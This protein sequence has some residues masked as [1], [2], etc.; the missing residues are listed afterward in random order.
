VGAPLLLT[1]VDVGIACLLLLFLRG[2]GLPVGGDPLFMPAFVARTGPA[3][4]WGGLFALVALQGLLHVAAFHSKYLLTEGAQLRLRLVLGRRL[5]PRT[6]APP[7]LSRLGHLTGEVLP[8][9]SSVLFFGIQLLAFVAQA[10]TL[11]LA[12]IWVAPRE[13]AVGLLGL[14]AAGTAVL[15]F[16]RRANRAAAGVPASHLA[17]EESKVRAARSWLLIR[18]LRLEEPERRRYVAACREMHRACVE[19]FFFANLG[20]AV[21]PLVALLVLAAT[22]LARERLFHTPAAAFVAFLYLFVRFQYLVAHGSH[23]VG[24][25]FTSTPY[26]RE[27]A[28]LLAEVPADDRTAALAGTAPARRSPAA[29]AAEPPPPP[30]LEAHDLSFRW[31]GQERPVL[32]GLT[33]DAAPGEQLGIVGPNGCGKSTFLALV[34]GALEPDRG[35]VKLDG[36]DAAEWLARHAAF[37]GYVGPE[38]CLVAGTIRQNLCYGLERAT[39]DGELL[40]ALERAGFGDLSRRLPGGLDQMVREDGGGLS[41]GEKQKLALARA[42]LRRPALL[43]LDEPTANVDERSEAEMVDTLLALRERCTVVL[44]SHEPRV[45]RHASR[46]LAMGAGAGPRAA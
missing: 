44:V 32:H 8:R 33:A 13:A 12:L 23:L 7:P 30:R 20:L 35:T 24:N 19:S 37:L 40:D 22:A 39:N 18:A 29:A 2:L 25:L 27:A 17:F 6:G 14:A 11:A 1:V 15:S 46:R 42:L 5:L 38:A 21:T 31:P 28:E 16:S 43:L 4:I 45:L 41:S 26:V 9:V 3:G 34:V 10:G 36:V